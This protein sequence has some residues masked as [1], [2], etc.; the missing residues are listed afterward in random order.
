MLAMGASAVR[1]ETDA[2]TYVGC[3][4]HTRRQQVA[5][6]DTDTGEISEHQLAHEGTAVE[7][8]YAALP[9]PVTI[10]IESTG[11]AIWSHALTQRR[12][13]PRGAGDAARPRAVGVRKTK[14]DRRDAFPPPDL[15]PH[16]RSPAVGVPDPATRDL[17][18]L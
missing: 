8:F 17:R 12:G 14:P 16:D 15:L 18:T 4:L 13:H 9:R 2:M 10:G 7:E 6:L 3:D 5:V 11:Y 1:K